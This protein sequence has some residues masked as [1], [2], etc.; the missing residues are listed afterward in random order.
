M[1]PHPLEAI[2]GFAQHLREHGLVVGVAEQQAMVRAALALRS[3]DAQRV[4]AGWRAVVCHRAD[5]W[6]RYPGLFDDYWYPERIR[7]QVRI[8]GRTRPRRDVRQMVADMRRSMPAAEGPP[9]KAQSGAALGG[10]N[11]GTEH[12]AAPR[13]QGGASRNE[14]LEHRAFSQQWTPQDLNALLRAVEQIAQRLRRRLLRRQRLD[15]RHGRRL[16]VRR[17]L[18][19]SLR[20]G[21]VPVQPAWRAPR[22]ERPRVFMLVDVSRSMETHAQVLLRIAR[23]F[24]GVLDAR[25]F[26]FH[27]RLSEVTALMQRDSG[28]MQDK[29][30]AVTAGLGG[31]TRI[32]TSIADFV[33]AHAKGQLGRG[34]RVLIASDGFDSDAPGE[35][36]Q[37]L[38]ALRAHGAK[39]Y[40]LHPTVRP[41]ASAA[42]ADCGA[43]VTAFAPLH[44][45]A[46]L[47][48]LEN[49]LT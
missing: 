45:L 4:R 9:G 1:N 11:I 47:A 35:L 26:V 23:A 42:L 34:A 22:R 28:K 27:T 48:R 31:G 10:A 6:R 13:A 40:W 18:R 43:L 7:G 36:S 16:D 8:G 24:A 37:Q 25:V 38:A 49:V 5:D 17:T 2:A 33:R 29:L 19:R 30:N 3:D 44:D 15:D 14:P 46:S 20:T 39:L 32:A 12:D 41:P 21:G